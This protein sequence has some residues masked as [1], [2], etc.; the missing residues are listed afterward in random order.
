MMYATALIDR[1]GFS[2]IKKGIPFAC[3]CNRWWQFS[4]GEIS[5]KHIEYL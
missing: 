5:A 1:G 3:A 4:T 2:D